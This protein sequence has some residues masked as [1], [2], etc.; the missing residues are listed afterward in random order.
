MTQD[1]NAK[2][3]VGANVVEAVEAGHERHIATE[4]GQD[5]VDL[6]DRLRNGCDGFRVASRD[7]VGF[8]YHL[9]GGL[10]MLATLL[11]LRPEPIWWAI[12]I[13]GT[14]MLMA[15]ELFNSAIERLTDQVDRRIRPEIKVIKD[16]AAA[17]VILMGVG[18][19][20]MGLIMIGVAVA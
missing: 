9:L 5:R 14:F 18:V 20:V 3:N 11:I 16:M 7:E 4:V 6:V 13:F 15:L 1:N 17:A 8:R 10:A 19:M 12:A 2:K